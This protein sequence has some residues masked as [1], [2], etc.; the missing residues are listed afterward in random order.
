M[1]HCLR[2]ILLAAALALGLTAQPGAGG[3]D[4]AMA[5]GG[6]APSNSGSGCAWNREPGALALRQAGK[7]VWQFNYGTNQS[8]PFF[9]PVAVPGGPVLTWDQPPDHLWHRALWFSW[10]Y[11]NGINYWETEGLAPAE[12]GLTQ[13][14]EPRIETRLDCSARIVMDLTYRP[15][16]GPAVL[17]EHRIIEISPPAGDSSYHLDWLITFT[18]EQDILLDRTPLPGEPGGQTWGGYAGLSVRFAKE[19]LEPRALTPEGLVQFAD[20]RYRGKARAMDYTGLFEG[21][22]AGI[23]ILDFPGNLNSPTPWYAISDN[24]MHYFS[25]AVIQRGPFRLTAGDKLSLRYRVVVHPSRWSAENLRGAADSF[26]AEKP[27]P[28]AGRQ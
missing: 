17:T 9:H 5:G 24:T 7:V 6:M 12:R 18:A 28:A 27:T 20:G 22:E 11:I 1:K 13:W 19:I 15:P 16:N 3:A 4:S 2:N 8:K 21:Q 23:A 14:G 25:P 26:A 10:K